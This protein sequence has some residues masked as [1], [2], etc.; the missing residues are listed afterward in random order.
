MLRES[1]AVSLEP[2]FYTFE[3]YC[4]EIMSSVGMYLV[5]QV[6]VTFEILTFWCYS[7]CIFLVAKIRFVHT[8]IFAFLILPTWRS[9]IEFNSGSVI[10]VKVI[11]YATRLTFNQWM[12][13]QK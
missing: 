4:F 5:T 12:F 3:L 1:V 6:S 9:C 7:P 13:L 11:S 8:S 2:E 10:F